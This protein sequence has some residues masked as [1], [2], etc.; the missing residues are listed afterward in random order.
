MEYI[1]CDQYDP[2]FGRMYVRVADGIVKLIP[3]FGKATGFGTRDEAQ[4]LHS[5]MPDR[6]KYEIVRVE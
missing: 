5:T 4:S 1:I 2:T 6:H 3:E